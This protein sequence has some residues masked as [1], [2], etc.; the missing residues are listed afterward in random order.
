MARYKP[1]DEPPLV[2]LIQKIKNDP[3]QREWIYQINDYYLKRLISSKKAE[4]DWLICRSCNREFKL[5]DFVYCRYGG[6]YCT[7]RRH[8]QC[9][10]MHHLV[11]VG[12]AKKL[13][14]KTR[15][16]LD[17]DWQQI[18][19]QIPIMLEQRRKMFTVSARS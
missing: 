8:L 17:I 18:R 9:A 16:D 10:I 19:A 14:R 5:G 6:R 2:A 3:V 4:A 7:I 13:A 15:K 11:T 12:E 1:G